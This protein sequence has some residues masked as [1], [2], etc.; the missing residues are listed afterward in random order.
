[1]S[2]TSN[3]AIVI[4]HHGFHTLLP[5]LLAADWGAEAVVLHDPCLVHAAMLFLVTKNIT[6]HIVSRNAHNAHTMH[7]SVSNNYYYSS[8]KVLVV[9]WQC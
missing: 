5:P 6:G 9:Q 1:M 7:L 4:A 8:S 3:A 2:F